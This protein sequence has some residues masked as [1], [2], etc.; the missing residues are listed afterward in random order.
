MP[1]Y[2][3][4]GLKRVKQSSEEPESQIGE[5]SMSLEMGGWSKL[6]ISNLEGN[7]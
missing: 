1:A 6:F 5:F 2:R 4:V 7:W 3:Y